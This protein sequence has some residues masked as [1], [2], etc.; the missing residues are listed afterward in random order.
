MEISLPHNMEYR[1]YQKD[2]VKFIRNG[3]KRAV[4][5][6][7]RRAG[8]DKTM[9]SICVEQALKVVGGYAYVLPTY[10]QGKKV[11][12]DSIDT[13]G[14][15]FKDHIPPQLLLSENGA[16]LKLTLANG[17][18]IQVLWSENIDWLRGMSVRGIV[19]SEYAFQNPTA[20]EVLSPI[21][22]ENGGWAIF[23]STPNG[24]N[25]FYDMY[26]M[27]KN[28]PNWYCQKLTIDDTTKED[29]TP[30]V[31]KEFIEEERRSWKD[32]DTIDREYYCSFDTGAAGAYYSKDV[33]EAEADG[34]ITKLPFNKSVPVDLY[35]DLGVNDAY[36][37]SFKQNDGLFYNFIDY[38]EQ[39]NQQLDHY[40]TYI[41]EWLQEK[42]AKLWSIH[43]PHDA[44]QD[45][46]AFLMTWTNILQKFKARFP[47]KV[48]FIP[49]CKSVVPWIQEVR[50]LF[51]QM[52]FDVDN[53]AVL[54]KCLLNYKKEWDDHKKVFRD[55]PCHDWASHGA[56]NIRYF[57]ES[58]KRV[59]KK[60]TAIYAPSYN[61]IN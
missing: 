2:V 45:W 46:Q 10:A 49:R 23:N 5:M 53:C 58:P 29:G 43:L 17:S 35:M 59:V 14:L 15:R 1:S 13:K 54:I 57:A 4:L 38:Y 25:H 47:W 11:I 60:K 37:I 3:W 34:R 20:W 19:F 7:H 24:K 52:R 6:Y 39:H 33:E 55:K 32:P 26:N 30:V 56:D 28:N 8:K 9:F 18:F 36:T 21:L 12:W 51:P 50:R 40:F 48:V 41:E 31:S 61:G 16:E 44:A 22:A 27:A 42:G